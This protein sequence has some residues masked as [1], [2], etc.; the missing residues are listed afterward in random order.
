MVCIFA[1]GPPG[2]ERPLFCP[3]S[4]VSIFSPCAVMLDGRVWV[5]FLGWVEVGVGIVQLLVSTW[6]G[7]FTSSATVCKFPL[8][9]SWRGMESLVI[10]G[11][12]SLNFL[13]LVFPEVWD[14]WGHLEGDEGVGVVE[15]VD[16]GEVVVAGGVVVEDGCLCIRSW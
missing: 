15:V 13:G 7:I 4:V 14:F 3:F 6:I 10:P 16:V 9:V 2:L 8:L 12:S 11:S 1:E 5:L